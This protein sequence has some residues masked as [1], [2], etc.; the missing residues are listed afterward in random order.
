MNKAAGKLRFDEVQVFDIAEAL[1]KQVVGAESIWQVHPTAILRFF[2]LLLARD[3]YPL[4]SRLRS[5]PFV[6][7]G[8]L[9]IEGDIG[10]SVLKPNQGVLIPAGT[11]YGFT[12]TAQ[13]D[14]IFLSM[15]TE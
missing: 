11:Y 5:D 4:A 3:P 7:Q 13:E 8:R 10:K 9:T 14:L 6:L 2:R 1:K 12:N 15:R